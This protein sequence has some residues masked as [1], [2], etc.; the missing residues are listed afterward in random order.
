[1]KCS[2]KFFLDM[3][4]LSRRKFNGLH[5]NRDNICELVVFD[6]FLMIFNEIV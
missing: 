2:N 3:L 6:S 4:T 5:L 1:M